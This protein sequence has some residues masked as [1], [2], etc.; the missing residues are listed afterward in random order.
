MVVDSGLVDPCLGN[1]GANAG[2]LYSRDSAN[3]RSAA[4]RI[5]SRVMSDGRVIS[6]G[7]F[8]NYRLKTI[9][10]PI[11][12]G[13][14]QSWGAETS[15]SRHRAMSHLLI[16]FAPL[17]PLN[18]APMCVAANTWHALA[19]FLEENVLAKI[20]QVLHEH[21]NTAYPANVCLVGTVLPNGFAQ[22]TPRGSTMVFDD[23]HIALWERGKGTTT[24]N[25]TDGTP[26]TI[27][28]RKP[29]L[30]ETA[31]CRKAASC[32]STDGRRSTNPDRFMKRSGTV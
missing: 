21:I 31:F 27:F 5:R 29:A 26:V 22:I 28:M 6:Q 13:L 30:R 20:S 19:S 16:S 8:S 10:R 17:P 9:G 18:R 2:F 32:G 15:H 3:S 12:E 4:L 24:E 11:I 7:P 1:N 23:E 14:R 25:L